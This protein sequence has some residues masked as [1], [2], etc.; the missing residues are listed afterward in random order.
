MLEQQQRPKKQLSPATAAAPKR[1]ELGTLL[2]RMPQLPHAM[3]PTIACAVLT[4]QQAAALPRHGVWLS[5]TLSFVSSMRM[6][7]QA[8]G[9][10][11]GGVR[12]FA[13]QLM[14][15]TPLL[16]LAMCCYYY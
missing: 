15:R 4:P 1:W 5:R 13:D 9:I 14:E 11:E 2:G 16:L 7:W 3:I 6:R 8:C 12:S 10:T